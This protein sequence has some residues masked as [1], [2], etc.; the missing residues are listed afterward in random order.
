[1]ARIN[2]ERLRSTMFLSLMD[3]DWLYVLYINAL[4]FGSRMQAAL[5]AMVGMHAFIV[6]FYKSK[7]SHALLIA[8]W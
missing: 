7:I 3:V 2:M 8:L 5:S 4:A 6:A 1:M